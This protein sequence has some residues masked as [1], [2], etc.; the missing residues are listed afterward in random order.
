[1]LHREHKIVLLKISI[2]GRCM[3]NENDISAEETFQSKSS[4]LQSKNEYSRRKKS[5]SSQK[6]KRKKEIISVGRIYVAFFL[7]QPFWQ[8]GIPQKY[9]LIIIKEKT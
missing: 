2:K 9:F 7:M 1:M 4:W 3:N 5:F 8:K 6:I